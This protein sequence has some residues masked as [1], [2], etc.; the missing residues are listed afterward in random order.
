[1]KLYLSFQNDYICNVVCRLLIDKFLIMSKIKSKS[2]LDA[3]RCKSDVLKGVKLSAR[4]QVRMATGD[5]ED[6]ESFR[7]LVEA[8]TNPAIT[9]AKK[10]GVSYTIERHGEILEIHGSTQVIIGRVSKSDVQVLKGT[11]YKLTR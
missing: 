7:H 9:K 4:S 10:K 6:N 2:Q 3:R 1:M 5:I 8:K 11:V